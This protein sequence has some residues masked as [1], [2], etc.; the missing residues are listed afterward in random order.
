MLLA[1]IVDV[2]KTGNNVELEGGVKLFVGNQHGK[3]GDHDG[4]VRDGLW[5]VDG[6]RGV[7]RRGLTRSPNRAVGAIA[8]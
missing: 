7:G 2:L 5:A 4:G 6:R 1:W 3:V 8:K